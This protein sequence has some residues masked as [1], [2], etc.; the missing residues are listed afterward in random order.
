VVE[1]SPWHISIIV[2]DYPKRMQQA[3][4]DFI[5]VIAKSFGTNFGNFE[6]VIGI[7]DPK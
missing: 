7:R 2:V 4:L 6:F 3:L 5:V 1:M